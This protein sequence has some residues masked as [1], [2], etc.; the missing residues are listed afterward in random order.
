MA[1]AVRKRFKVS[2]PWGDSS[3][4]GVGIESGN[5]ILRVQVKSTDCRTQYGLLVPSQAE[6]AQQALH[7]EADRLSCGVCDSCG[8]PKKGLDVTV[9]SRYY[10]L[11]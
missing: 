4:Y 2:Q 6:R 1:C 5:L 10:L 8:L 11:T 7:A 3:A 9:N